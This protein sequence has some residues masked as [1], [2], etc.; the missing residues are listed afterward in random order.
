MYFINNGKCYFINNRLD[1]KFT[2]VTLNTITN[3]IIDGEYITEI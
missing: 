1:V 3:T 2:G